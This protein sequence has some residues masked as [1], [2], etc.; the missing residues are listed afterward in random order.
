M[1]LRSLQTEKPSTCPIQMSFKAESHKRNNLC[2]WILLYKLSKSNKKKWMIKVLHDNDSEMYIF[3]ILTSLKSE[4]IFQPVDFHNHFGQMV[5]LAWFSSPTQVGTCPCC[6][7][8]KKLLKDFEDKIWVLPTRTYCIAQEA[9][10][11][12]TW[13]SG[14]D[15]SSGENGYRYMYGWVLLLVH[16][17]VSQYC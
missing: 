8:F 13:Q 9:L 11:N 3:H 5:V 7:S 14:W 4:C 1:N 6:V 16:P 17:K 10:F 12:A 15:R 2:L